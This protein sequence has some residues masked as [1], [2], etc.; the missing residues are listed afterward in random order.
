[1][2][3]VESALEAILTEASFDVESTEITHDGRSKPIYPKSFDNL[4]PDE[5]SCW[6]DPV[7]L[8]PDPNLPPIHGLPG[9]KSFALNRKSLQR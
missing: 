9:L 2:E 6:S 1:M 5:K 7:N 3:A 8:V 4:Q